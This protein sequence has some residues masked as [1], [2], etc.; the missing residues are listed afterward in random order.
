MGLLKD[1]APFINLLV[2]QQGR[3]NQ[4]LSVGKAFGAEGGLIPGWVDL[5]C[6]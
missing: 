3:L 5:G 6:A 4:G 1:V 2:Y